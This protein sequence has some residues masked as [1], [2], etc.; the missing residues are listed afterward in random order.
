M[1]RH[2]DEASTGAVRALFIGGSGR[3]GSTILGRMLGQIPGFAFVGELD[4]IWQQGLVENRLCGCGVPFRSCPF[5]QQVGDEAFGGWEAV[6]LDEIR[7]IAGAIAR[8]RYLPMSVMPQMS[9]DYER[10]LGIHSE[11][12]AKLFDGIRGVVKAS[13]VVDSSKFPIRAYLLRRA[14]GIDL[15]LAHLVRDSRAVAYSWAKTVREPGVPYARAYMRQMHPAR[16]ALHWLAFNALCHPLARLGVPTLFMRY[17][18]LIE[19]PRAEI[20]KALRFVDVQ[21]EEGDLSFLRDDRVDLEHDHSIAGNPMR[22]NTGS[23]SLRKDEEW[24]SRMSARDKKLVTAIT[25]PLL[26]RYGYLRNEA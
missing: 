25:L 6:D 1:S 7:D 26:A 14:P 18:S 24:K 3:S 4:L 10:K 5:W 15:R 8:H 11:L 23:V 17:E 9:K 2:S 20:T 13:V 22:F 19:E 21:I 16:S 12:V